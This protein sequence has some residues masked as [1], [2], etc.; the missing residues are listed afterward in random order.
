MVSNFLFESVG[1][2]I[3][4]SHNPCGFAGALGFRRAFR[5][6]FRGRLVYLFC[7]RGGS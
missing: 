4:L 2:G 3:W 1:A 5:A 6:I 7:F